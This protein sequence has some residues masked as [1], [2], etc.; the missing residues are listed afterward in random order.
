[1]AAKGGVGGGWGRAAPREL[2][3]VILGEERGLIIRL[4][5]EVAA[6]LGELLGRIILVI[7]FGD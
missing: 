2:V 5:V 1:M 4:I 3:A 7:V 6:F